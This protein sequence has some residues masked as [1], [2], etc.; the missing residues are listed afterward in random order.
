MA[1]SLNS[2]ARRWLDRIGSASLAF[3]LLSGPALAQQQK[4]QQ[5]QQHPQQQQVQP[6]PPTP[7]IAGVWV[8]DTGEGAIEIGLC[9][10][11]QLCGQIVWLHQPKDKA[12]KPLTDGYNPN[13]SLR[14]RPICGLQV[15]G[16]L[17]QVGASTWDTG[18]IY[19]PKQGKSFDVEIRLRAPDRLQVKGYLGVKILSETFMWTRAPAN[20]T[21][22]EVPPATESQTTVRR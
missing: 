10:V 12:G 3:V 9:G 18:W 8:D 11:D 2:G 16:D 5:K 13:V 4:Q 15:I 17:K 19:D 7:D 21:R 20:L 14:Q 1:A 22:C 6:Q